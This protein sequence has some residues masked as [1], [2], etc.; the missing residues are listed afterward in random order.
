[1]LLPLTSAV[2]A[3]VPPNT[4]LTLPP[5]HPGFN[6][7]QHL[8][9]NYVVDWR[10][11]PAGTASI[12]L[13]GENDSEH[14]QATADSSGATNLIFRVNDRY[15]STF[16]RSQ[17]CSAA[18]SKQVLEGRRQLS[19]DQQ[20][21]QATRRTI[22]DERN[23]IAHNHRTLQSAL[24]GCVTDMLSGIFAASSQTIDVGH[25]LHLPVA[26]ANHVTD[27]TLHVEA[28]EAV[29]TPLATYQTLRVQATAPPGAVRVK[30]EIW[31]WY[32]D[33]ERHLPVQMRAHL[34]WG[35]LT[36]RLTRIDGR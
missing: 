30:G 27:V 4:G 24:P 11:F 2:A 32:T 21:N 13:D 28:R 34:P 22:Y 16:S 8:T 35:T 25:D 18:F 14:V 23:A 5:P 15:S 33:D 20:F 17:G 29:R 10:V 9:L 6:F 26:E 36:F 31:I 12:R 3:P 1:M 7:P 19:S